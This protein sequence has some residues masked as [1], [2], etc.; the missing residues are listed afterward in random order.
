MEP[1]PLAL[2]TDVKRIAHEAGQILMEGMDK[3][4]DVTFKGE[5]D[6]V[7][8][9]DRESETYIVS[10]LKRLYPG[11][12]IIAEE[13][14]VKDTEG[15]PWRWLIDPLDGTTNYIH[16]YPFFCVS[17]GLEHNGAVVLGVVL[18]PVREETFCAAR[19]GGAYLNDGQIK[20]S[21][22]TD[23]RRGL[24]ATGFP[25]SMWSSGRDN[26]SNLTRVLKGS[27]GVRRDGAAALDLCYVA[28]GRVDGFWELGLKPW[29]TAAGKIIV[30]EAGGRLTDFNGGEYT[31]YLDNVVATNGRVHS[32]LV[33]QLR[34]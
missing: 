13:G 8:N 20:V 32:Q 1:D 21:G 33:E 31:P 34:A 14:G 24:F 22:C 12:G 3:A 19:G 9:I 5:I 2:L 25:Y 15:A 18:D 11:H 29:D 27:Q 17:I 10:E 4:L 7:T 26:I 16:R 30:E 6:A 28:C 23:V